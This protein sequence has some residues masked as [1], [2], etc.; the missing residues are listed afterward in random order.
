MKERI[1][2]KIREKGKKKGSERLCRPKSGDS[3]W[4]Y[5]RAAVC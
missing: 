5:F 3:C 2:G 4:A 1:D